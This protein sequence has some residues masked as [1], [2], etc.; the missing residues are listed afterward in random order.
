MSEEK[1]YDLKKSME[2]LGS[3]VPVL[4]DVHGNVID[5][6]HRLKENPNCP[7]I[8]V[9]SVTDPIQLILA[10]M[11]ANVCRRQVSSEEKIDWLRQLAKLTSWTPKQIAQES[12]MSYTWVMKYL[13]DEYKDKLKAEAGQIGGQISATRR[14]AKEVQRDEWGRTKIFDCALCGNST[15]TPIFYGEQPLCATC[16]LKVQRDPELLRKLKPSKPVTMVTPKEYKPK[17][18]WAHRKASMKVPVSHME[19]RLAKRLTEA[20]VEFETQVE[21]CIGKCIADFR[22][23]GIPFFIDYEELHVKREEKDEKARS[24]LAQFYKVEPVGLPY[25]A[26]TKEEEER[27]LRLIMDRIS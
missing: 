6:V 8:T 11:A 7:C 9:E 2:K 22:I 5:G 24:R 21:Y 15:V 23:K 10:R 25:K 4:K 1:E 12:G 26:D 18:T 13:P 27:L 14:V 17:E 3:L 20:G 19:Q 16:D